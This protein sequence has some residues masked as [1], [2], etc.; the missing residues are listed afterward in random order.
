MMIHSSGFLEEER[1]KTLQ[2][3]HLPR[4]ISRAIF[5]AKEN[6]ARGK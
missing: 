3:K 2:L 1:R 4:K 6:R 5:E